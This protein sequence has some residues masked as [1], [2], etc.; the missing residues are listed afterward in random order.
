MNPIQRAWLKALGPVMYVV[1]EK[2]ATRSGL[3]GKIGKFLVI[4]PRE[5]GRHSI[6][7]FLKCYNQFLL[8]GIGQMAH[9]HS[10]LRAMTQKGYYA[11]RPMKF[12]NMYFPFILVS[13]WILPF[14]EGN[15]GVMYEENDSLE[16]WLLK[17]HAQV[18]AGSMNQRTSAHYL[19]CN[20]IYSAEML[21][22]LE[23]K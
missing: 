19:E 9:R 22:R 5:Y 1:N 7:P 6:G 12:A 14:Y 17:S 8:T 4:G 23:N 13:F 18:P 15:Q 3:V 2:L 20:R 10:A 11:L 16:G 21:R